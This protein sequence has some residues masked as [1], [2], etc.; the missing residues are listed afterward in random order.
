MKAR[1]SRRKG[2][3]GR[4]AAASRQ[5]DMPIAISPHPLLARHVAVTA[6]R[7][8][9]QSGS[10]RGGYRD[11]QNASTAH[12]GGADDREQ[13]CLVA[14]GGRPQWRSLPRLRRASGGGGGPRARR[15]GPNDTAPCDTESSSR[16]SRLVPGR[17]LMSNTEPAWR[18]PGPRAGRPPSLDHGGGSGTGLRASQGEEDMPT[19]ILR[20]ETPTA[21][22]ATSAHGKALRL[23]KVSAGAGR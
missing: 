15:T 22:E 10:G 8:Y 5:P 3:E 20:C 21:V 17:K 14:Q 19:R 18:S 4:E 11:C 1:G 23:R 9:P 13:G 16:D 2:V 12:G 7:F 6:H